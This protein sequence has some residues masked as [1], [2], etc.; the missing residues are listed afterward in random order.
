MKKQKR[1]IIVLLL[2]VTSFAV[3]VQIVNRNSKQMTYR[4]KILKAVYPVLMWFSNLRSKDGNMHADHK[5][6][7]VS[8]YTL[9]GELNNGKTLD[10]AALKGKKVMVVNTA[11]DCGFTNQFAELQ[12]LAE[13][14][15]D[16]LVVIGFP[17][18]DF[19]EQEKKSD[20]D[21]AEFCKVNYG[22]TF[23]LI[24]KS[25][26]IKTPAQHPVFQWLTDPEKNGWNSKPP[27]WNFSKYI[28]N[29]EGILTNYFGPTTSPIGKE[30]VNVIKD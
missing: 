10:F 13:K 21:I 28:I 24:K 2:I 5:P 8:F 30:I 20:A 22:V 16:E 29:E 3:Y 26:V 17:A 12:E 14:F 9:Q 4:Q 15:K 11:S 23:P 1:L 6:P 18:N 27:S 7:N 19:K 25:S